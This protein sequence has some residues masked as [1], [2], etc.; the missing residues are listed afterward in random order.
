VEDQGTLNVYLGVNVEK[1]E[2]GKLELT[3]P[4][5]KTS[6]LKDVEL[7]YQAK[8]NPATSRMTPAYHTVILSKDEEGE[9]HRKEGFDYKQVIGK[10]L[11]LEK[12]TMPDIACA[13]HLC[14]RFCA[15][16]KTLHMQAVK[17][18]CRYLLGT[19]DKGLILDL[20][21]DSFDCW[22][23]ASH[24]SEWSG[25]GAENDPNTARSRMGYTICCAGCPMLWASKMQTEIA[26]SS[27]KAE[28][29]ALS[30]S[31]REFLPL[32]WL[33]EEVQARGIKGNAK[34]CKVHCRVFKDN[35]GAIEIATVPKKRPR[36]KHL[37]IKYHHFRE[38]VKKGT[39]SICHVRTEKQMADML[40]KPLEETTFKTH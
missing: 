38:E 27:T 26:P 35:E 39:V 34:P 16:P 6:V 24:A 9:N 30:K 23:D 28:Y 8:G 7:D 37:N 3:Q 21:D 20:R 1:R 22:V 14:A 12:S 19:R 10:L 11:Y 5:L 4:T 18:I 2:D 32:M 25:K 13:V 15:A 29:I 31:M 33:L 36:T 17:H 40:T